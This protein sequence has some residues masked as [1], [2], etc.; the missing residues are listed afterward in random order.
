MSAHDHR[1]DLDLAELVKDPVCGMTVDPVGAAH[2]ADLNGL[3][4]HFCSAGCRTKFVAGGPVASV[5]VK[6]IA[7]A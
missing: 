1:S 6:E 5:G 3:H 2:R 4:F 7:T